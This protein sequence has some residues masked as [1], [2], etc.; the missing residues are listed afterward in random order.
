[1]RT[2]AAVVA[3]LLAALLL[4]QAG[5]SAPRRRV[6]APADGG[7]I[8]LGTDPPGQLR[9]ATAD[10]GVAQVPAPDAGPSG[11]EK[12]ILELR[13][14]VDALERQL[15]QQQQQSQQLEQISAQLQQLR[16]QVADAE[17]RRQAE[18]QV[19]AQQ[20]QQR[21]GAIA[22]LNQAQYALAGG[23][24]DIAAA[25]D[26]AEAAFTGQAQRDVQAARAALQNR[27]LS[28][29]RALLGAAISDAQ[30]GR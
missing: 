9:R 19:Q 20:R 30:Q 15:Q 4:A 2:A 26:R 14:R 16:A 21:E 28:Q 8:L 10:A 22:A 1:M 12:Q 25:L 24:S 23:N 11:T 6:R 7:P 5:E 18:E 17:S 29:A 27:D 13:A 3:G